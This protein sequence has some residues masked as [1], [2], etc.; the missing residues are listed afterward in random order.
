MVSRTYV[1]FEDGPTPWLSV[2]LPALMI[3]P[4]KYMEELPP[5]TMLGSST[6]QVF[7]LRSRTSVTT[8]NSDPPTWMTLPSGSW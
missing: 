6:D 8:A 4:G 2:A 3:L 5:S 7:V 1:V